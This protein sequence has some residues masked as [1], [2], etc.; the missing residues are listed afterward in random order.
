MKILLIVV[1]IVVVLFVIIKL[2]AQ[3]HKKWLEQQSPTGSWVFENEEKKIIIQFEQ[4]PTEGQ[5][6][7]I[8][9]L[10]DG[11]EIKEFGHWSSSINELRML[12]MATD[13][14]DHP[15]FGQDTI[16]SIRYGG[17]DEIEM[18]EPDRPNLVY[19]R[20]D[21]KIEFK[22]ENVEQSGGSDR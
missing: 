18:S 16:Y 7:Q 21:E 15:R 10:K 14:N 6:K 12:I 4:S 3:N 20:T 5:Y 22:L 1:S 8:V 2:M 17:P 9:K 19:S 13:E 11:T